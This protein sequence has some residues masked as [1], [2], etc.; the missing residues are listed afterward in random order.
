MTYKKNNFKKCNFASKGFTLI[1]MIVTLAI[2]A[3]LILI[4]VPSFTNYIETTEETKTDVYATAINTSVIQ[5]LFPFNND[6]VSELEDLND[7]DANGI[8][9]P[10]RDKILR[11]ADLPDGDT[12]EFRY[13]DINDVPKLSTYTPIN[14]T[15]WVVY[16]PVDD[17]AFVSTTARFDFVN[18][19]LVFTPDYEIIKKYANSIPVVD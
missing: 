12:I 3:I 14:A 2:I 6:I 11:L 16:I 10:E 17:D 15:T 13:Y 19:V 9:S 4:A 7:S 5:T 18:D 8:D 1:E